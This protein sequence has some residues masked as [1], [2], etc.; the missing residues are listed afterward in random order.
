MDPAGR[1]ASTNPAGRHDRWMWLL[2]ASLHLPVV[3]FTLRLFAATRFVVVGDSMR[4][5]LESHQYLLVDRLA[6]RVSSPKRGDI[7]V[8]RDP[9]LSET[10]SVKRIIGL[11]GE[12]I[13]IIAGQVIIDGCPL[14]EPY[15]HNQMSPDILLPSQ[16]ILGD[17]EC[18]VLGD[19]RRNSWDS[20]AFGPVNLS[21]VI[22]RVW[23]RYW[24]LGVV[25]KPS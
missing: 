22:G 6:Y 10:N 18:F 5:G 15:V 19:Y 25:G 21:E 3:G 9:R 4:P 14:A 16:W 7:V 8:F 23:I 13:Q 24:P 17:C 11:P 1:E 20:R 2:R 12:H